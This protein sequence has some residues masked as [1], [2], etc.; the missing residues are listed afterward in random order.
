MVLRRSKRTSDEGIEPERL[1]DERFKE[2]RNW[3]FAS[4]E[5]ML[6]DKALE[7]RSRET[8]NGSQSQRA[9]GMEPEI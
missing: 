6:P 3:Q 7:E 9:G 5:G 2:L 4:S 1:L 8:R